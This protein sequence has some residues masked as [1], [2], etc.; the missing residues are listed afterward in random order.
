MEPINIE[1]T[2]ENKDILVKNT[3]GR[4][5]KIL[6]NNKELKASETLQFLNYMEGK[7]YI[8]KPLEQELKNDKNIQYVYQIFQE[9]IEKLNPIE[10][11]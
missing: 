10:E 1:V 8:L 4:Q 11:I 3:E 5:I 2:R 9:I 6:E 7:K